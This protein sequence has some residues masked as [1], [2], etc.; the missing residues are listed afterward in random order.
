MEALRYHK[1]CYYTLTYIYIYNSRNVRN[2]FKKKLLTNPS[3]NEWINQLMSITIIYYVSHHFRELAEGFHLAP[4]L[5]KKKSQQNNQHLTVTN[6]INLKNI[7][8]HTFI[9][10]QLALFSR[11]KIFLVNTQCLIMLRPVR[12]WLASAQKF[13]SFKP[14]I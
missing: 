4:D 2:R 1:K 9:L 5:Q 12:K 11:S 10:K 6:F 7:S 8:L 3:S 14:D 13:I